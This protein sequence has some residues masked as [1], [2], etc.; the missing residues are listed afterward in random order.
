M[1]ANGNTFKIMLWYFIEFKKSL[2]TL[3]NKPILLHRKSCL[4]P[5]TYNTRKIYNWAWGVADPEWQWINGF[6]RIDLTLTLFNQ[7]GS[8]DITSV[9]LI[10]MWVWN[11]LQCF[12]I[13]LAVIL[14][15]IFPYEHFSVKSVVLSLLFTL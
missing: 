4:F 7:D 15:E 5:N 14:I 3:K 8:T 13:L 6:N 10:V 11:P 9:C 1:C 12:S 2:D